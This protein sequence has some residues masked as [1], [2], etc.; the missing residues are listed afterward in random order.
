MIRIIKK[1]SA[2]YTFAHNLW[3]SFFPLN[4][5]THARDGETE[6]VHCA[7]T[8][9]GKEAPGRC[10]RLAIAS[11]AA[12]CRFD[13][14]PQKT[15]SLFHSSAHKGWSLLLLLRHGR[16]ENAKQNSRICFC[17]CAKKSYGTK[18]NKSERKINFSRANKS[19]IV[20]L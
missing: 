13:K 9:R 3:L 1:S 5:L 7:R 17:C 8:E 10:V 4:C 16:K 15:I 18:E 12:G 6:I 11:Q 20:N 19:K 14:G 2:S